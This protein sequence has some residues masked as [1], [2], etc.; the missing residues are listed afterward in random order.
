LQYAPFYAIHPTFEAASYRIL[1][2]VEIGKN[3]NPNTKPKARENALNTKM[4][5]V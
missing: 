4:G 2:S 5:A 3:F 1:L